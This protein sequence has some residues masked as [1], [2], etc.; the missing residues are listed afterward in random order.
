M[1]SKNLHQTLSKD[2]DRYNATAKVS[3]IQLRDDVQE[4]DREA[5]LP[6][7]TELFLRS[8]RKLED[9]RCL[10]MFRLGIVFERQEN[11]AIAQ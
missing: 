9:G 1:E 5:R 6:N 3:P 10:R 8:V 7:L 11:K 4:S 2:F